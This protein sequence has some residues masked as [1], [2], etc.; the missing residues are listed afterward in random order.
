MSLCNLLIVIKLSPGFVCS[1]VHSICRSTTRHGAPKTWLAD[2]IHVK[3]EQNSMIFLADLP[4]RLACSEVQLHRWW[5]PYNS[6]LLR[7]ISVCFC[8]FSTATIVCIACFNFDGFFLSLLY[9]FSV[10]KRGGHLN[11]NWCDVKLTDELFGQ[12]LLKC[13]LWFTND[14]NSIFYLSSVR[15]FVCSLT[16][17]SIW[18]PSISFR[19]KCNRIRRKR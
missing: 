7:S 14:E 6:M 11:Q 5:P 8:L 4:A 3:Y 16:F 17:I 15:Q 10:V 12:W 18:F 2:W 13:N 9:V 19:H 1:A